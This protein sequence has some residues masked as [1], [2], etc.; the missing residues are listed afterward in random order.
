MTFRHNALPWLLAAAMAGQPAGAHAI[1]QTADTAARETNAGTRA[2]VAALLRQAAFWDAQGRSEQARSSLQRILDAMPCSADALTALATLELAQ[3]QPQA[4][5]AAVARLRSAAPDDPRLPL[6]SAS[7]RV[8]PI[9]PERLEEPRR[10]AREGHADQ[11]VAYY[12]R[13]FGGDPPPI[14]LAVEYYRALSRS[15]GGWEIARDGLAGLVRG[16]PADLA[17]QLAYAEILTYRPAARPDGIVRLQAL[18]SD[19]ALQPSAER[20]RRT[21]LLAVADQPL[22]APPA[23]DRPDV[24]AHPGSGTAVPDPVLLARDKVRQGKLPEAEQTLRAAVARSPH[25]ARALLALSSLM[26]REGRSSDAEELR[27]QTLAADASMAGLGDP[28]R[29]TARRIAIDSEMAAGHL[30]RAE[31]LVRDAMRLDP[32]EPLVWLASAD[33]AR[34]QGDRDMATRAL[35]RARALRTRQLARPVPA[36]GAATMLGLDAPDSLLPPAAYP[37]RPFGDAGAETSDPVLADAPETDVDGDRVVVHRRVLDTSATDLPVPLPPAEPRAGPARAVAAAPGLSPADGDV[38]DPERGNIVAFGRSVASPAGSRVPGHPPDLAPDLTPSLADLGAPAITTDPMTARIDRDIAALTDAASSSAQGAAGFRG[39]S[40]AAGTSQLAQ[41]TVPLEA[42]FATGESGQLRV[43]VTPTFLDAG[44]VAPR[45]SSLARFGTLALALGP[46]SASIASQSAEGTGLD[47]AHTI[48]DLTADVGATPLGFPEQNVVG[49]LEWAPRLGDGVRLRLTGERRAV[50][51]SLLS[52]AGARDPRT[53]AKW[54]GVTY[55]R[56]HASLEFSLGE[57]ADLYLG[58]GG[59]T[60][61][62]HHVASNTEIEA[63][64][65]GR[66]TVW[67]GSGEELRLGLDLVYYGFDRN[68]RGFTWGQGGYFSPQSYMA[69]L[70]PI[71]WKAQPSASLSYEIGGTVGV[72]SFR[73]DSS[74][75]YA[76]DATLQSALEAQQ[77]DPTT[78]VPGV[79][80]HLPSKSQ[81]GFTGGAHGSVDYRL[82]PGFHIGA[83]ADYQHTGDYNQVVGLLYGRYVFDAAAAR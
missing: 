59:G 66:Y 30:E 27:A 72:Q 64:A 60:L 34:A 42:R 77:S 48:G 33:L 54:G 2:A 45:A 73:Q 80:T 58:G 75:A 40:G 53:G 35:R 28:A 29:A 14:A 9:A 63:S 31:T 78:A 16:N 1:E 57:S 8:G 44:S 49:G 36:A 74:P 81:T 23:E 21:A 32:T 39:R 83:K 52:Y 56:G 70:F 26:R 71:A 79:P 69:A 5:Q 19:P 46:G 11:A 13:L 41:V 12:D 25:D 62:G 50:T 10:L 37:P 47:V 15:E 51:D 24:V 6:L 17:A 65:G 68:L 38:P 3:G 82:N 43:A 7:L 67:R 76:R 20:A 18:A 4:A 55:A 22:D 61:D